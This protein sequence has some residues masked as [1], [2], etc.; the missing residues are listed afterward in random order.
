VGKTK[1]EKEMSH[2][3]IPRGAQDALNL[4]HLEDI[5]KERGVDFRA[6]DEPETDE[7]D[8][9]DEDEEHDLPMVTPQLAEEFDLMAGLEDKLRTLEG[10]DHEKSM[11]AMYEEMLDQARSI[12]DLSYNTDERSRR[13]LMEIAA[14]LYKQ[15]LDAKNSKR[16]AQ[17]KL[18]QILLSQRRLEFEKLKW[19][20]SL[21]DKDGQ[22]TVVPGEIQ[23]TATVVSMDRNEFIKQKLAELKAGSIVVEAEDEDQ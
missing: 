16:D 23:A 12:M 15:V 22:P 20:T 5:L 4:P 17:L 21:V 2:K 6:K 10:V 13:G 8:E 11:D 18:M 9:V 1:E 19:K 7:A 3:G 14:A